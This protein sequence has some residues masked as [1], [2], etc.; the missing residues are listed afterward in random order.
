MLR[1]VGNDDDDPVEYIDTLIRKNTL[2]LW[3]V[4]YCK[5]ELEDK[6]SHFYEILQEGNLD[7]VSWNDPDFE[8]ALYAM[9]DLSIKV[10]NTFEPRLTGLP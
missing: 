7:F 3:G 8:E 1:E 2:L 6:I 10:V 4:L 5:G 9:I